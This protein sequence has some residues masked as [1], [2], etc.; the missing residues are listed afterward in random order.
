MPPRLK[1]LELHGY[2]TFASQTGFVFAEAVTAIVGPNGSGKSNIADSIRWVLGEQSFSLLRGKK[3]EDMIFSGSELRPR[4]SMAS[5]TLSFDNSDGWLPI[6]FSEVAITRR[7]YRDGENE[8]LLN[9]QRVRLKDISELLA[10]SGLAERTYTVIGQGLVD[11]ALALK[12]EERRRL[13]EEAAGIGLYRSRREEALRRLDTTRHNLERVQDIL[14][15]L[16]PRLRSLERQAKRAQEYDQVRADLRIL[17][18]DWYGYYWHQSQHELTEAHEAARLREATLEQERQNHAVIDGN[19]TTFRERLSGLRGRLNSW[20]HQTSQLHSRRE[21]I[22]RDLAVA[23]ERTRSLN[24]QRQSLQDEMAHLEDEFGLLRE[25][26]ED[27]GREVDSLVIELGEARTQ[28][29]S[30]RQVLQAQQDDRANAENAVH[31]ARQSLS[32]LLGQQGNLQAR[33]AERQAQEQRQAEALQAAIRDVK[34][35]ESELNLTEARLIQAAQ[36]RR[37]AE[38]SRQT[39]EDTLVTHRQKIAEGEIAR[40]KTQESRSALQTELARLTAQIEVLDQAEKSFTGYASGTRLL[41]QAARDTRLKGVRGALSGL[42]EVPVEYEAAIA[43]ALGEYTDAVIL[44]G[45]TIIEDALENLSTE[46]ARAALMPLDAL[47]PSTET[48]SLKP[49][50]A[51]L[52][53][54]LVHCAPDLR[55][56]IDLLL[57]NA[58][59]VPDRYVARA[60][61]LKLRAGGQSVP[62]IRVITMHGEVFHARG[63]IIAGRE[64]KAGTLGR[65]R[66]RREFQLKSGEIETQLTKVEETLRQVDRALSQLRTDEE[67]LKIEDNRAHEVEKT[68]QSVYL[69][70]ELAVEK[71]HRQHQFLR[72]VRVRLENEISSASVETQQIAKDIDGL[73]NPILRAREKLHEQGAILAGLSLDE[74][75]VQLS[76]WNTRAA[77]VERVV[78]DAKNRFHEWQA[79]MDRVINEKQVTQARVSDIQTAQDSLEQE[80][81]RLRK[82]EVAVNGEI[83]ELQIL[84]DPSEKELEIVETQQEHA[85]VIEAKARQALSQA[86]HQHAQARI[87]L[88]RRQE[89]LDGLRQRIEDDFGLVAFDYADDVSGPTPLPLDGMVEQL[90]KL[91]NLPFDLEENI[92]R[93]RA[94]LRRMGPINAEA[95]KEHEE[96]KQRYEFLT[97]QV[98]DLHKAEAGIKEV[99]AELDLLMEREFRKTFDAVAHEF[100]EIFTRLFGGGTARLVLTDPQDLTATGIDIEA[101]LPGRREQGLSL[102]SGGE[103]SLTASALVFSLLKV[104]PTPF[105]VFDEVDAMLDEANVGRF[106]ILLEEL[107][108]STQFIIITH[109]RNTVQVADVIYGITMGRDSASQVVSLKLDEVSQIVE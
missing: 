29:E 108:Q 100:R 27:A 47:F 75:Q 25:R 79:T 105:C 67:R 48:S 101:R 85:Q 3:T 109:N 96:V 88:A 59:V 6:D 5:A 68:A 71:I 77:V 52:A 102:L 19:L 8:Y 43:A 98:T 82:A 64:S 17:L 26:V 54:G 104:S 87:N 86:E 74:A 39:C 31:E 28:V 33:L 13:F 55:P 4:A 15:E 80:K 34:A 99:I 91:T 72:E 66:Q 69:E 18:R 9:G 81:I 76:H 10:R 11:A 36:E 53:T 95:Q 97:M 7:A 23:D 35:V 30:T 65:P 38:M 49:P 32:S 78:G 58:W 70:K 63:P 14:A 89:T 12:A 60:L 42:I 56:A 84:I 51:S 61:V 106:R 92:K 62:D 24:E 57:G 40:R 16:L 94:L 73:D 90:P 20:H 83:N 37:Q 41:L 45:D 21:N 2:K 50:E 107:A 93:Q 22:S 46:I 1:S 44:E 103:R